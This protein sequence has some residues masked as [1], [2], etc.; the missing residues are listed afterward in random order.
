MFL[1]SSCELGGV[2]GGGD[3]V[4]VKGTK[5]ELLMQTR[6]VQALA[7]A[8]ADHSRVLGS[9]TGDDL[10]LAWEAALKELD[11]IDAEEE[12]RRGEPAPMPRRDEPTPMPRVTLRLRGPPGSSK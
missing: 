2:V 1:Q 11:S 8:T 10:Q 6:R 9:M 5:G 7:Q 3:E 12:P 4:E